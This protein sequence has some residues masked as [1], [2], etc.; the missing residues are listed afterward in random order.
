MTQ[1]VCLDGGVSSKTA[2]AQVLQDLEV[3]NLQM[4]SFGTSKMPIRSSG[5]KENVS[6]FDEISVGNT[7]PK[8]KKDKR[9]HKSSKMEEVGVALLG[10]VNLK[11]AN[12]FCEKIL[13][14]ADQL[15]M[16]I[17]SLLANKSTSVNSGLLEAKLPDDQTREIDAT[18]V[19]GGFLSSMDPGFF[20]GTSTPLER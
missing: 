19:P 6:Q 8:W 4:F 13:G 18:S 17:N 15:T 2:S 12:V 11:H 16:H 20:G 3:V 5:G 9:F 1:P 10:L 14:I 7:S